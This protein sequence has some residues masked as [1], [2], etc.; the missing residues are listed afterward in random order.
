MSNKILVTGATGKVSSEVVKA[1][2]AKGEAVRAGAHHPAKAQELADLGA[3][4]VH[5]DFSDPATVTAALE[6]VD[7]VFLMSPPFRPDALQLEKAVIDAAKQAGV[8]HIADLSAAGVENNPATPLRQTELYLEASGIPYT[9]IRPTWFS[10][11]FSTGQAESIKQGA[12]YIPAAEGKAAFIDVR[13]IAAVAATALSEPGH[14]NKAYVLTS[15]QALDHH[16]V[17]AHLSQA[18][19]KDVK[20]VPITDEQF[21]ATANAEH[22]PTDAIETMSALYS[23]VRQGWAAVVTDQVASVLG[24]PP[25]TFAQ[26]AQD[27]AEVW[28]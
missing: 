8:K 26:F 10:Q 5:F 23:M 28:K 11:N 14:E 2:L 4:V 27:H 19:G 12:F 24:R 25:I 7:R 16:E 1:L 22:W 18:I 13:D 20:Y 9:H 17:A 3:E 6:G 21:R 15:S